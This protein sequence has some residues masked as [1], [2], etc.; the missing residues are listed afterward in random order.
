[1]C[2]CIAVLVTV[3]LFRWK[4]WEIACISGWI[5]GV[6]SYL[7][8]LG[9]VIISADGPRTQQHISKTDPNATVLLILL[10]VVILLSNIFVGIILTSVGDRPHSHIQLLVG[11]S[12]VAVLLSWLLLHTTFGQ[13][14]ARIYY[15]VADTHGRPFPGGLRRGL[16]FPGA[17]QPAYLD[18]L[19]VSFTIALTYATS[20]VNI[21]CDYLRKLVLI[22]S[23]V[24]F[25]FYSISLG[26]VL[27]AVVTS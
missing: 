15:D 17:N 20:D 22:H 8:L 23:L 26:S 16:A 12:M 13:Q 27:N 9:T 11:F 24:S 2:G 19:Y 4:G 25:F 6:S 18:F 3:S 5:V 14:Y 7:L 1:M 21:E 10:T